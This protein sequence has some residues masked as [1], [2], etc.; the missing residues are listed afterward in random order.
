MSKMTTLSI[1]IYLEFTQI[2]FSHIFFP[3]QYCQI[4]VNAQA[5]YTNLRRFF[6]HIFPLPNIAKYQ[7]MHKQNTQVTIYVYLRIRL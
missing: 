2:F 1:F 6:S 4:S 3:P 5:K 7:L